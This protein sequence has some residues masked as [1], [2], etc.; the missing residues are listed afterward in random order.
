MCRDRP[1][2]APLADSSFFQ[3]EQSSTWRAQVKRLENQVTMKELFLV[4]SALLLVSTIDAQTSQS[5]DI[6]TAAVVKQQTNTSNATTAQQPTQLPNT[7][8][9][10]ASALGRSIMLSIFLGFVAFLMNQ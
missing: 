8:A 3:A 1:R 7:P 10:D 4:V 5:G 2:R 6:T 9:S